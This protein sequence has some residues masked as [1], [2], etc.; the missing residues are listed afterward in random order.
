MFRLPIPSTRL[1]SQVPK[2]RAVAE[3]V[4]PQ[5]LLFR[6]RI[7]TAKYDPSRLLLHHC[8]PTSLYSTSTTI[9]L[10]T[11]TFHLAADPRVLHRRVPPAKANG[12]QC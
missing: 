3:S 9:P 11:A 2:R 1:V 10:K 8:S 7:D 5:E 12:L 4:L 6:L